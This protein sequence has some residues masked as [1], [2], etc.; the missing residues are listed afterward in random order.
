MRRRL[1]SGGRLALLAATI[2]TAC[3]SSAFA[4]ASL[5]VMYTWGRNNIEQLGYRT[6]TEINPTQQSFLSP[7]EVTSVSLGVSHGLTVINGQVWAWGDNAFGQLG[8]PASPLAYGALQVEGLPEGMQ[9]VSAGLYHSVALKDGAL[10]AWGRNQNGQLGNGDTTGTNSHVPV[11]VRNLQSGVTKFSAGGFHNLAIKD[12]ALWAWGRNNVGQLGTGTGALVN[13]AAVPGM[14]SGV[15]AI[16]AGINHSLAIKDGAVYGWGY[17]FHGQVGNG[18]TFNGGVTAPFAIPQLSSGFVD[19]AAG[20]FHSLALTADGQV[21]A[22]GEADTGQL[23][24][25]N[26]GLGGPTTRIGTPMLIPN[27]TG[28]VDIAASNYNS[29][30]L[31]GDGSLWVWGNNQYGQLGIGTLDY[32]NVPT[33]IAPPAGYRYTSVDTGTFFALATLAP[34]IPEPGM[35]AIL[36]AIALMFSRRRRPQ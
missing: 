20:A 13:P 15:T 14:G 35:L 16:D 1:F 5:G 17:N 4:A 8:I 7:V 2:S 19:V 34:V 22:W 24:Q 27:L 9:H 10:W 11:T 25:P 26:L 30:A 6:A 33:R 12:G 18:T 23:G 21:W 28:I 3:A 31:A 29:Y 32:F 36:P